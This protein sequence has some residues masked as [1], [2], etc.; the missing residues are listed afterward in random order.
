MICMSYLLAAHCSTS[1]MPTGAVTHR[2]DAADATN[3]VGQSDVLVIG[4]GLTGSTAAFYLRKK[5]IDVVLAESLDRVGGNVVSK[6]GNH[7]T[8]NRNFFEF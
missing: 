1:G 2:V 8:P 6:Q 7:C 5:G 3:P 4:S